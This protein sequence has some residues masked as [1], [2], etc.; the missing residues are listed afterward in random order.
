M[1]RENPTEQNT[2]A[3]KSMR[4]SSKG[5]IEKRMERKHAQI[6]FEL[7]TIYERFD[8][9]TERVNFIQDNLQSKLLIL[10]EEQREH[11]FH[12]LKNIQDVSGKD[13]FV[14]Q[15]FPIFTYILDV[16]ENNLEEFE[17]AE[18]KEMYE[19]NPHL[20]KLNQLFAYEI[21]DNEIELHVP[22]NESTP[23]GTML[24][25]IDEGMK[26]IAEIVNANPRIEKVTN[27]SWIAA[28][29][30]GLVEKLGFEISEPEEGVQ[31]VARL[32]ISRERLLKRWLLHKTT[33][34][35]DMSA[36]MLKKRDEEV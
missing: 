30:P 36:S 22:P 18:R 17:L 13:E 27:Y 11:V 3:E 14:A 25:L 6:K 21:K 1:S 2:P 34:N 23:I 29:K 24:K 16:K 26:K 19:A 20:I 5:Q 15:T 8:N 32:T 28:E 33:K 9:N 35:L 31:K 10:S 7:E 4:G 12:L